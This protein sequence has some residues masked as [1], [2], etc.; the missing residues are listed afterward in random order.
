MLE[1]QEKRRF[2]RLLY[3]RVTL[4]I[5]LLI[6]I[7]LLNAVWKVYK[8]QDMTKDNLTKTTADL[9]DL[10][11]REK[12][13]SLEIDRLKTE[14]GTEEE[15]REKYGLVRPGEEVLVVVDNDDSIN[16]NSTSTKISFWQRVL[17]WLK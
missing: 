1:F 6:L 7:W 8:K 16:S 2:R 10:K 13:L 9:E 15:I 11:A 3:S 5:L 17:D 14:G 12:M 4:V